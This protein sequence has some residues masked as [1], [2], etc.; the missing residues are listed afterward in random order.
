MGSV[1]YRIVPLLKVPSLMS[2]VQLSSEDSEMASVGLWM[3]VSGISEIQA[4]HRDAAIWKKDHLV[5][6]HFQALSDLEKRGMPVRYMMM[7]FMC[8]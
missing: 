3:K 6:D 7:L 4:F 8:L 1:I 5:T 2:R